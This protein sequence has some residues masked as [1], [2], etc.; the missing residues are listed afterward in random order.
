M[1]AISQRNVILSPTKELQNIRK[2]L[3]SAQNDMFRYVT[4][5]TV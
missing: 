2:V 4:K 5:T 3:R 1:I